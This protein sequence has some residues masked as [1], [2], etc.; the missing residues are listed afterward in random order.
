MFEQAVPAGARTGLGGQLGIWR[1][2]AVGQLR[3][4]DPA[5]L[6]AA[7]PKAQT[8]TSI[9]GPHVGTAPTPVPQFVPREQGAR[10][11]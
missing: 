3:L 2:S 8:P 5:V 7:L 6:A 10:A 1:R 9:V 4:G 11:V